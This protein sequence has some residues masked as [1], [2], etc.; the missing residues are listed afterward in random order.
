VWALIVGI[1]D[2]PGTAHDLTAAEADASDAD[3]ALAQFGV[4]AEQRLVL[5][6][7]AASAAGI[8]AG[9]E[10]LVDNAGPE[11]TAVVYLAGHVRRPAP[12]RHVFRAADG[13]LVS[14]REMAETLDRL[15]APRLWLAVAGCYGAGFDEVIDRPGRILSGASGEDEI[16]Y[17]NLH[18]GRSYLGEFMVRRA[19]LG[20]GISSVRTAFEAAT[21]GLRQEFPHRMPVL[22]DGGGDIELRATGTG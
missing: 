4:P 2:Y 19:M 5:S 7:P 20:I 13:A 18:L 21:A 16:A 15:Q 22:V 1:D 6:G 8:R 12:G 10:W 3:A 11:A 14:D 9:L 17:E